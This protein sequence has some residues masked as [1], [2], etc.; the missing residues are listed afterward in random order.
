LTRRPVLIGGPVL[1]VRRV[2]GTRFCAPGTRFCAPG[3][4][5]CAPGTRFCAPGTRFCAPGTR[6]CWARRVQCLGGLGGSG[7]LI[8][9]RRG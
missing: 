4:R 5:F 9:H 2:P 8:G 7:A 3:T 6:F 1:A